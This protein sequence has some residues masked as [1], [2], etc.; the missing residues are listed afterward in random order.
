MLED[1][2]DITSISLNII[3]FIWIHSILRYSTEN[4]YSTKQSDC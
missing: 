3:K 1:L 4:K 2:T